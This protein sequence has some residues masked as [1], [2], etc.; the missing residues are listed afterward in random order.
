M[1]SFTDIVLHI[2]KYLPLN[3]IYSLGQI[4]KEFHKGYINELN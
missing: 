2:F 4:N 3:D 1:Q